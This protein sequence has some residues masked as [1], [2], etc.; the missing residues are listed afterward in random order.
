MSAMH[1]LI[2]ILFLMPMILATCCFRVVGVPGLYHEKT[3]SA[4]SLNLE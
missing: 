3:V 4:I 1:E 2:Q